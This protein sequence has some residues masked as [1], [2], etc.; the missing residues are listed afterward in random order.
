MLLLLYPF[1]HRN[2]H[3]ILT[4]NISQNALKRL[5]KNTPLRLDT[6]AFFVNEEKSPSAVTMLEVYRRDAELSTKADLI[7]QTACSS[8]KTLCDPLSNIWNRRSDLTGVRLRTV[9]S[10]V[11]NKIPVDHDTG[12]VSGLFPDLFHDI[13]KLLNFTYQFRF[14]RNGAHARL[15]ND[16]NWTGLMGLLQHKKADI[17]LSGQVLGILTIQCIEH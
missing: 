10:D 17:S 12:Q 2:E 11:D 6:K 8:M 9:F 13:Q 1:S 16:G 14:V 5:L 7:V 4:S 3:Y 15:K